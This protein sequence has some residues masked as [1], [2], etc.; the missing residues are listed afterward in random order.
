M[1]FINITRFMASSL[2]N[3]V[4]SFAKGIHEIKCKQRC[5]NNSVKHAESSTKIVYLEY[6]NIKDDL[7]VYKCLCCNRNY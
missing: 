5:D 2:S 7:T 6:K 3:L 1:Q 4:D